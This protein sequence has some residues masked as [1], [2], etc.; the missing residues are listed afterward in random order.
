M[1]R[2]IQEYKAA[3]PDNDLRDYSKSKCI[4]SWNS[5]E[6]SVMNPPIGIFCIFRL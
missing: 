1:Q 4:L 6:F 5:K 3:N 2:Y